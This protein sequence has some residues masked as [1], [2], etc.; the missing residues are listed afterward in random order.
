VNHFRFRAY[1]KASAV[2]STFT[3]TGTMPTKILNPLFEVRHSKIHGHGAFAL[4]RIRQGTRIIEYTGEEITD[5]EA[6][7]R[8]PQNGQLH[9]HTVLFE[10]VPGKCLDA[11]RGGNDSRFI[12]HSCDPNCE[13][14]NEEGRIFIEALR[15]IP[16]ETE[17]TY[18]YSLVGPVPRSKAGKAKYACY[19]G[20]PKCRGTMLRPSKG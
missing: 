18:D 7:A 19:C 16:P 20:S 11:A 13:A 17:L 14:V 8:Y 4:R 15:T 9:H 5:A 1:Q 6:A 10:T 12:N 3:P 2:K